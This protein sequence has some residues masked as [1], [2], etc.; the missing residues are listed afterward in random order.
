MQGLVFKTRVARSLKRHA[1]KLNHV[2]LPEIKDFNAL[3]DTSCFWYF[4][5]RSKG[6]V[7]VQFSF[8]SMNVFR[9]SRTGSCVAGVQ[10]YRKL[11]WPKVLDFRSRKQ[12]QP[13]T[14]KSM[15]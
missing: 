8:A 7:K 9:T 2:T 15:R 3:R 10:A 1:K 5:K 12:S 6:P 4:V 13:S 11:A 14:L